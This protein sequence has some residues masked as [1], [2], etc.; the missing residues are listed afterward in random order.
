MAT[1]LTDEELFSALDAEQHHETLTEAAHSLGINPQ[2]L[3]LPFRRSQK[4]SGR[5]P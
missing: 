3:F 2:G 1:Q 4:S 5:P